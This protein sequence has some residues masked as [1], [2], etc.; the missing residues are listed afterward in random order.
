MKLTE[1]TA[2]EL[3]ESFNT[4]SNQLQEFREHFKSGVIPDRQEEL[5]FK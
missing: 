4:L 3:I 1:E 5:I 2:I